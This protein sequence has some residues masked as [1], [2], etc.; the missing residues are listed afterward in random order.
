MTKSE[1]QWWE[2]ERSQGRS[3][4]ILRVGLL[5]RG[6][7]FG[8]FI[9][10]GCLLIDCFSSSPIEPLWKIAV[11][12]GFYTLGFGLFMGSSIWNDNER[13]FKKDTDDMT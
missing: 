9:T 2:Q 10:I 1:K 13:D 6:L 7:P 4:F 8:V 12:F 11:K 5:R 3:R